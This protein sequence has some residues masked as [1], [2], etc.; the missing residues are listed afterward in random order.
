MTKRV[1]LAVTCT[2]ALAACNSGTGGTFETDKGE[3]GSYKLDQGSDGNTLTIKTDQGEFAMQS[4]DKAGNVDLPPGFAVY[5]GAKVVANTSLRNDQG[6][7]VSV[8][9]TVPGS[10]DQV[11]DYYRRQAEAAGIDIQTEIKSG[12]TQL[13]GGESKSGMIFS[14]NASPSEEGGTSAHISLVSKAGK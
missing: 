4:G 1:I 13:I 14:L 11:M 9:M 3:K 7:N 12:T 6:T 10:V 8:M 5:P 2:V